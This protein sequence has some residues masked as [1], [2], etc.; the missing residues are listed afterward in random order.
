MARKTRLTN[1]IVTPT[2]TYKDVLKEYIKKL[3][4]EGKSPA[5][6]KGY[7]DM[8]ILFLRYIGEDFP[9]CKITYELLEDY[10]KYIKYGRKPATIKNYVA[11]VMIIL[12][13]GSEMKYNKKIKRPTLSVPEQRKKVYSQEDLIKLLKEL[14]DET[15]MQTQTR[16]I[17]AT[18][19]S[20]GLRLSELTS[21][22]IKDLDLKDGVIYSRHTKNNKPRILPVSKSLKKLLIQ[23]LDMRRNES[24][25]ETLF[26]NSYGE[27]LIRETLRTLIYRYNRQ[28]GVEDTSIHQFRRTFITNAIDKGVD[29]ISLSRITGHS[30]LKMLNIYYVSNKESVKALAD[31]VSPLDVLDNKNRKFA[32]KR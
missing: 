12:N 10:I 20:T 21:L 32:N 24:D 26:C 9:I 18:F 5:T 11:Y 25:E 16:I 1:K 27:P 6:I 22:L 30:S 19:L 14:P 13:F 3:E 4:T 2:K 17:I 28:R 8:N 7:R 23:W 29:I 31:I 15:F